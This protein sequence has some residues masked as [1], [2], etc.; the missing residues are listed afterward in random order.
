MCAALCQVAFEIPEV[1]RLP[2]LLCPFLGVDHGRFQFTLERSVKGF[3]RDTLF[4]RRPYQVSDCVETVGFGMRYAADIHILPRWILSLQ[5]TAAQAIFQALPKG[6]VYPLSRCRRQPRSN[7]RMNKAKV[8]PRPSR[9]SC[10]TQGFR[11]RSICSSRLLA[12]FSAHFGAHCSESFRRCA[13]RVPRWD[14]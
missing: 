5:A 8:E 4:C 13:F 14:A 6:A 11:R 9:A 12:G 7:R 1:A 10:V 2:D 3:S